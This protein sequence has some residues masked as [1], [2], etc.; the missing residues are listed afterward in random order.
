MAASHATHV[1][2]PA[3]DACTPTT[4]LSREAVEAIAREL[5]PLLADVFALYVKTKNFHWHMRGRHVRDDHLVLDEQSTPIFAMTDASAERA[6][7]RGTTTLHSI[8]AI[9][10]HQRV[11]DNNAADVTP[12]DML[13][14]LG[15]DNQ[16][17][18]RL[19]RATHAVCDASHDVATARVIEHWM[20]ETERRTWC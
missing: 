17:L 4:D 20:D 19:L 2:E 8:S 13:A 15:A 3:R 14:E 11:Q 10:R 18:T 9:A 6:R 1:A 5:R 7:K 12:Q 16:H